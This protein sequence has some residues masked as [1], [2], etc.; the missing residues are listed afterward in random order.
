[1]NG[2]ALYLSDG[3]NIDFTNDKPINFENNEFQENYADFFGGAIYSEFSKLNTASVKECIIKNNHAG[4]MGGGIYSPKS[5]SQT[6][7][8]LDDVMFKNNKV[9]SN[10]DNYSS[11]PSYITLD[12]KFDSHPLNFT[13]G[14]N[15]PLLFSLHNDFDNIVYDYTKYY[16]I[17]L[18]VSLIRK[19]EIANENYD[20]DEDKK[21]VNLIGNV[22]TFVYGICELK[23]FKIL[24]VPDIYILKF[25][26]EGLEEYIEIKSNDIEIQINTCDDNQIEMKNKNGILYC[27]EPICNKNCPVNSTAICIK[28]ST[29]NVN[30]NENNICKCTEGWKGFTCNEKIYENLS[31]IKKSIIIENSI[32]TIII[33]SNIIF[34][35]YNR[36]QR[37]INDIGV[38]KMVLFSIGIFIYFTIMS[39][40]IKSY[41]EGSQNEINPKISNEEICNENNVNIL[42][43]IL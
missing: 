39:M 37:I 13:T 2:G 7:F 9:Y 19:N 41:E 14:A 17:T 29:K 42:K 20:E 40:T 33:I 34:I 4:I 16:S 10:D 3:S 26:V 32:I 21:S 36:N 5:I 6:L 18:K 31:P 12:T 38:T 22:G 43:K 28:G 35:L 30:N 27:E 24:A 11:K 25:V 15:I 8:S 1:M 23:N